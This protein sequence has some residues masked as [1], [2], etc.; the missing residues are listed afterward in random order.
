MWGKRLIGISLGLAMLAAQ[1]AAAEDELLTLAPASAWAMDYA[2]DSCALRREFGTGNGRVVL[3]IEQ[4]APGRVD[5]QFTVVGPSL[6]WRNRFAPGETTLRFVPDMQASPVDGEANISPAPDWH[7][8]TF[9]TSFLTAP[10]L[11]AGIAP[12]GQSAWVATFEQPARERQ[13]TALEIRNGTVEDLHLQTGSMGPPMAAM[14]TCL[15]ELLTH[16]GIDAEAHRNLRQ[17]VQ[18]IDWQRWVRRVQDVYPSDL[19]GQ[20]QQA[21]MRI[22]LDVTPEGRA[23]G[24]HMQ[25]RVGHEEFERTACDILLNQAR[26]SPALDANGNAIASYHLLRISY[27]MNR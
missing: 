15:D 4:F 25:A 13:V 19:A 16:W 27:L 2:D 9:V 7:G 5:M 22:R 24:C 18:A 14:R 8:I 26:F 6:H 17:P 11:E 23:S 21:I 20:G 1:P 12:E 3:E 10:I